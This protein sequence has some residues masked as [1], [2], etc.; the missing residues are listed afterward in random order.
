VGAVQL[1]PLIADDLDFVLPL[2]HRAGNRIYIGQW[3]REEHLASMAH[4]DRQHL[5]IQSDDGLPL[6][7]LIMFDRTDAGFGAYVKRIAI[8]T[9]SEGT[10]RTALAQLLRSAWIGRAPFVCLAVRPYNVRAQRS[11]RAAGFHEWPLD[12]ATQAEFLARV[13]PLAA[14]CL[15]MKAPRP[16]GA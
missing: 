10:G 14:D 9:P 1:R 3:S 7:Y 5:L 6:G 12:D 8:A 11:Y 16:S 2:E 15:I 4:A 13:D